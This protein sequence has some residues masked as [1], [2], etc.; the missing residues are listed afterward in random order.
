MKSR[1]TTVAAIVSLLAMA[2]MPAQAGKIDT[3][4]ILV[5]GASIEAGTP[6]A[7]ARGFDAGTDWSLADPHAGT[8]SANQ[9]GGI[10]S[11]G[12]SVAFGGTSAASNTQV[13]EPGTIIL[14]GLGL[15]MLLFA[16]RASRRDVR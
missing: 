4:D 1:K 10:S 9:A 3:G 5:Q 6:A 12:I 16:R 15:L 11:G 13:P 2:G 7:L 8:A 14:G